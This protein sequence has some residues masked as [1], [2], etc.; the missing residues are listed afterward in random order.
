MDQDSKKALKAWE[1]LVNNK[2]AVLST[3]SSESNSPQSSAIYYVND[4]NFHLFMITPKDSKKAKNILKNNKV[5]LVVVEE[6]NSVEL[7]IEGVVEMVED[8]ERKSYLA[9][10]YLNTAGINWPPVTKLHSKEGYEFLEI[11]INWFKYSDFSEDTASIVEG[12]PKDWQ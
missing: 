6:K 12:T 7:Q 11:T 3:I 9:D 2:L 4:E 5:S 10:R 1:C 8:P